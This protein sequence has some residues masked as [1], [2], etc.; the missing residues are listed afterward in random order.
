MSSA[1]LWGMFA[2][3]RAHQGM[4]GPINAESRLAAGACQSRLR[5]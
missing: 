2:A 4:D 3:L 5:P 1:F